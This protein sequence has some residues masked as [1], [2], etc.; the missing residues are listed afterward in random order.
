MI[1]LA[2]AF[3]AGASVGLL[4]AVALIP[5]QP[6]RIIVPVEAPPARIDNIPEELTT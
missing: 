6:D 3:A 4:T 2:A 5:D 1:R